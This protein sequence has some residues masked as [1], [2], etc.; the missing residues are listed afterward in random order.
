[1]PNQIVTV[2][3]PVVTVERSGR[4]AERHSFETAEAAERRARF[5]SEALTWVG[6]PFVDCCD[7][8]GP[9]GGVDCAMMLT[10][11]AVDTG[12][13]EPFDPRPYQPRHMMNSDEQ[14]FLSWVVDR[15]G[16][17]EVPAPRLGDLLIWQFGRCFCHGG[18]LANSLEVVHAY[19]GEGMCDLTLVD[20]P[21]LTHYPLHGGKVP[22]PVR[23][24]DLWGG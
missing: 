14:L 23:Y 1:M 20:T 16:A 15:F 2:A 22:R 8:K 7:V 9:R 3:G 21:L 18:V 24:F 5:V 11:S 12:L 17:R 10:R 6:T 4:P 19:A 13:I